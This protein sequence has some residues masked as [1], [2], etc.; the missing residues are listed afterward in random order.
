LEGDAFRFRLDLAAM[1]ALIDD[2]CARD[3]WS[4]IDDRATDPRSRSVEARSP[5]PTFDVVI[6]GDSDAFT[7][8][9]RARAFAAARANPAVRA[10][11]LEGAGH[12]VHVDAL[13]AV[14]RTT[15]AALGAPR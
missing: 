7:P 5:A 8:A 10:T 9:D 6:G 11:V 2:Y 4:V 13:D 12:W 15:L 14:V 3:L 1:R